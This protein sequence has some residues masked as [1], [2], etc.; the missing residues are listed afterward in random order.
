MSVGHSS[1]FF[2]FWLL[3]LNPLLPLLQVGRYLV[4]G[5]DSASLYLEVTEV[6]GERGRG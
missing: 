5:A 4:C 6:N 3:P 1:S 2:H